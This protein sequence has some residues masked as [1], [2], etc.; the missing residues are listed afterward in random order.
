MSR[1]VKFEK[2]N[3]Y[4]I[5]NRG[6]D[7]KKIF[8]DDFDRFRFVY[9]LFEFN[10]TKPTTNLSE[11]IKIA[12]LNN[13]PLFKKDRDLITNILAFSLMENHYHLVL[14]EIKQGGISEFLKKLGTGYTMYFN[15]KYNRSG[16]L[17]QGK[18]K[19]VEIKDEP[20]FSWTIFYVHFNPIEL[21]EKN[22]KEK[23]I[24]NKFA[25][26]NFLNNYR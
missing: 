16:V 2:G 19:A 7:K 12:N 5:F 9:D 26:L 25:V 11:R 10:D 14:K 20:Q 6:V 24:E 4:H 21:I 15:S 17:F 8:L 13:E 3:F 23:T 1:K 22:W 18:F